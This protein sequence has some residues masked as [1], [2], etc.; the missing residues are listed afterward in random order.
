MSGH[1]DRDVIT[2][3]DKNVCSG[4]MGAK[5]STEGIQER[6]TVETFA[7]CRKFLRMLCSEMKERN[8]AFA[9]GGSSIKRNFFK[10]WD[11]K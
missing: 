10:P 6:R 7:K 1:S 11:K 5:T 4:D 2:V 3:F 9:E 8:G